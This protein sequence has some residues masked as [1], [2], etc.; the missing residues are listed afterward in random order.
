MSTMLLTRASIVDLLKHL[1]PSHFSIRMIYNGYKTCVRKWEISTHHS[2]PRKEKDRV[3]PKQE[4]LT[5]EDIDKG[6]RFLIRQSQLD[7]FSH[8]IKL[9]SVKLDSLNTV[10]IG[11][12]TNVAHFNPYL[13]EFGIIKSNS[14]LTKLDRGYEAKNP[15]ILHRRS[16]FTKLLVISLHFQFEHPVS[17]TAVKASVRKHNV[18]LGLGTLYAQI[19]A[20]CP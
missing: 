13:D 9:V 15:V 12:K 18:I 10:A 16:N 17:F 14:K 8:K 11:L 5:L 19:K 2:L 3:P 4:L 6:K 7:F 20:S 1:H